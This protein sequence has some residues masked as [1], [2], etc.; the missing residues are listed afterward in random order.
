VVLIVDVDPETHL[1]TEG[2]LTEGECTFI[3]ARSA[4]MGLKLAERRPPSVLVV[5]AKLSGFG[6]LTERLRRISPHIH[7]VLLVAPDHPVETASARLGGVGSLLRKPL[8]VV[9]FRSTLRTV[10]RLSAMSAGVKRMRGA[11]DDP[12]T[13]F[14]PLPRVGNGR[15]K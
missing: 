6:Y 8:D 14:P 5:D 12:A 9:R 1:V 10:L 7:L 15:G 4:E 3:G 13:A 2:A 11:Q